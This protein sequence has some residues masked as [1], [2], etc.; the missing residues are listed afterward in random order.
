MRILYLFLIVLVMSFTSMR[1][2]FSEWRL[3]VNGTD[4]NEHFIDIDN[5]KRQ[6]HTVYF[7]RLLNFSKLNNGYLSEVSH[8]KGDCNLYRKKDLKISIY[9]NSM[10]RGQSED[11]DLSQ[12]SGLTDWK[13][14][15]PKSVTYVLFNIVCKNS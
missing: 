13:Y 3:I 5:I 11:I 7:R 10:G 15:K 8:I 6:N 4:S 2:S 1:P 12:Y 14:L 9:K